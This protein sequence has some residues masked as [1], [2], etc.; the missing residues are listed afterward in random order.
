MAV[1]AEA[2]APICLGW[3]CTAWSARGQSECGHLHTCTLTQPATLYARR[4]R[5]PTPLAVAGLAGFR[6]K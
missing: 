4:H 6:G 3:L 2:R 5:S 1:Q